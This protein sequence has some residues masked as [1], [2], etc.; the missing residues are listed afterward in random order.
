[1]IVNLCPQTASTGL[2]LE[3]LCA[4]SFGKSFGQGVLVWWVFVVVVV[5]VV[6]VVANS[7]TLQTRL[8]IKKIGL[9]WCSVLV[10]DPEA[11]NGL[12]DSI[13]R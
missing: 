8:I 6:F 3:S 10:Q 5:V 4:L 12:T 1:M 7:T 13:F 2:E 9:S 11:R